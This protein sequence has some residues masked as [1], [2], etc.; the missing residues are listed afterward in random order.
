MNHVL[1]EVE[2]DRQK[3]IE[4]YTNPALPIKKELI[5]NIAEFIN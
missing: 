2:R 1:K 5:V 4:T 3:N